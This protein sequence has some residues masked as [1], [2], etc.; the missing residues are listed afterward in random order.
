MEKGMTGLDIHEPILIFGKKPE[1][2]YKELMKGLTKLVS[3]VAFGKWEDV[4]GDVVDTAC[5][6]G[7]AK[8]PE[9]LGFLLINR[10]MFKAIYELVGESASRHLFERKKASEKWGGKL[11]EFIQIEQFS[12]DRRFFDRPNELPFNK[13][14]QEILRIWLE[15]YG[16]DAATVTN[17]VNRLPGYFV[18]A[19]NQ[20]WRKNAKFY[21][22]LAEALNTPFTE[23]IERE[24]AWRL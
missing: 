1:I 22:P 11:G 18:F 8:T 24:N 3:H 4:A 12:L 20:E 13:N 5:G 2:D 16:L 19:L 9:E 10:A 14:F 7:L 23:A 17:I 21:T 15:D 6:L